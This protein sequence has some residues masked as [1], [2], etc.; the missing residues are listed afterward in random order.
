MNNLEKNRN[1]L[2]KWHKPKLY[3]LPMSKTAGGRNPGASEV[4]GDYVNFTAS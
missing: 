2:K 4:T 1:N 3:V